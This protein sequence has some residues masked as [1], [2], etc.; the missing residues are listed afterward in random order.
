MEHPAA[1]LARRLI[2]ILKLLQVLIGLFAI[3]IFTQFLADRHLY[4]SIRNL[5][6]LFLNYAYALD[7]DPAIPRRPR[8][9]AEW[10]D[11]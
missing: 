4:R 9:W 11:S 1:P 7:H 5:A 8:D 10:Y 2:T 3:E 6:L